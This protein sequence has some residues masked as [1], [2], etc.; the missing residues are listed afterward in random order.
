[1]GAEAWYG[2][3]R[4]KVVKSGNV[5]LGSG[6]TVVIC[7]PSSINCQCVHSRRDLDAVRHF[8]YLPVC[9]PLQRMSCVATTRLP[10]GMKTTCMPI[11]QGPLMVCPTSLPTHKPA[12]IFLPNSRSRL[13]RPPR[14]APLHI[15]I[16]KQALPDDVFNECSSLAER[17][18]WLHLHFLRPGHQK[19]EKCPF[20]GH[21]R[22]L[23]G[24]RSAKET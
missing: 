7:V 2:P 15:K 11:L 3:L 20:Q 9:T 14:L 18:R 17:I 5:G 22:P 13:Y 8:H 4:S 6:N 12:V 24:L 19:F 1:M 16:P 10:A 23:Q 21:G